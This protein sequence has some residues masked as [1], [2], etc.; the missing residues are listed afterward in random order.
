MKIVRIAH[1]GRILCRSRLPL[2][3][4]SRKQTNMLCGFALVVK[5]MMMLETYVLR[6]FWIT[7]NYYPRIIMQI[8]EQECAARASANNA[9]TNNTKRSR[10]PFYDAFV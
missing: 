5:M 2:L 10:T 3:I 4:R 7:T 6:F 8:Q 9:S 1:V